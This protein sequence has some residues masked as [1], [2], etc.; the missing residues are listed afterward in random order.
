LVP[1]DV[2]ITDYEKADKAAKTALNK[3]IFQIPIPCIDLK[4]IINCYIQ[5]KWQQDWNLQT[6]N[7][8]QN[9]SYNSSPIYPYSLVSVKRSNLVQW[10]S[11]RP[12]SSN[13]FLSH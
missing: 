11:Y 3:P 4:P 10:T 1:S 12:Y 9:L 6:E 8:L 5:N 7:K 2:G 13:P